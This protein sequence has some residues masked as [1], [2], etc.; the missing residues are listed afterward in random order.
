[1]TPSEL[2]FGPN[3]LAHSLAVKAEVADSFLRPLTLTA[4]DF[5]ALQSTDPILTVLKDLNPL[6]RYAKFKEASH[7]FRL[8]FVFSKSPHFNSTY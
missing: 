4:T 8:G 6:K 2:E 1:M 5:R 3:T 7:N